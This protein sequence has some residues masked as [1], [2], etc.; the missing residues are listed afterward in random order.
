MRFIGTSDYVMDEVSE[1]ILTF[2]TG[3]NGAWTPINAGK[4]SGN[5]TL[6]LHRPKV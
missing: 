6:K 3:S 1:Q 5:T 2:D 4:V